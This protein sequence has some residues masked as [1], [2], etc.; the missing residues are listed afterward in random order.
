MNF[1]SVCAFISVQ[2]QLS[3]RMAHNEALMVPL[4]CWCSGQHHTN[5][6]KNFGLSDQKSNISDYD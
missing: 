1:P 6:H 4:R 3:S 2:L 5:V